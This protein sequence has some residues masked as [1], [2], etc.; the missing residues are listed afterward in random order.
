[1]LASRFVR[2]IAP[3]GCEFWLAHGFSQPAEETVGVGA[4]DHPGRI[5]RRIEEVKAV[6]DKP[7]TK[8]R[9]LMEKLSK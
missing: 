6:A 9:R 7:F 5:A 4:D 8:H 2:G 3:V 1:M